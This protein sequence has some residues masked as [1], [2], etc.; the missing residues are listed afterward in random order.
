MEQFNTIPTSGNWSDIAGIIDANFLRCYTALVQSESLVGLSGSNFQGIYTSASSL[1]DD[2]TEAGWALVGTSLSA[3]K[4]YVYN[5]GSTDWALLNDTTYNFTNFT[6]FQTQ[7][8]ALSSQVATIGLKV[9]ELDKKIG[10]TSDFG[11]KIITSSTPTL[12]T[13][14]TV[15]DTITAGNIY[16]ITVS[17]VS[18]GSVVSVSI[19]SAS[20]ASERTSLADTEVTEGQTVTYIPTV[21]ATHWRLWVA[22]ATC[23]ITIS[24]AFSISEKI[25]E[26]D[27]AVQDYVTLGAG[28]NVQ[29]DLNNGFYCRQKIVISEG[30]W[31]WSASGYYSKM[32]QMKDGILYTIV[33]NGGTARYGVVTNIHQ[34]NGSSAGLIDE[35]HSVNAGKYA[36]V[37]GADGLW[38]F[39]RSD[40]NKTYVEPLLYYRAVSRTD[41]LDNEVEE[42]KLDKVI[43]DLKLIVGSSIIADEG[44]AN[45]GGLLVSSQSYAYT[46][47]IDIEGCKRI[48]I[49]TVVC[50]KDYAG[51]GISGAVLYD[52]DKNPISGEGYFVAN[53]YKAGHVS[54]RIFPPSNAVYIR[55]TI[56]SDS[57]LE[58]LA[59]YYE[60]GKART[61]ESKPDIVQR[62]ADSIQAIYAAK[63]MTQLKMSY[64][65]PNHDLNFCIAHITDL[66]C[67]TK[68]YA[69][70]RKF[71]DSV[72]GIDAAILTGDL[73]VSPMAAQFATITTVEGEK[74]VM[75]CVGN[76]DKGEGG[77]RITNSDL[78]TTLG[79]DTDTGQLYYYKDF[80]KTEPVKGT[81]VYKIR[82]IVLN[83]YDA[84]VSNHSTINEWTTYSQAQIDWFI[85]TLQDALANGYAVMIGMHTRDRNMGATH[86]DKKFYD[87]VYD[88]SNMAGYGPDP[89]IEEIVNAFRTGGSLVKDYTWSNVGTTVSVNTSFAS[90]GTFIAYMTGHMHRDYIAYSKNFPD[91]L[92][93]SGNI[94]CLTGEPYTNRP[95]GMEFTAL[96]RVEG[97]KS[98]DCFNVYGID[99]V[100]KMV[101]VVRVGSSLNDF[102]ED[103]DHDIYEF[104]PSIQSND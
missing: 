31:L 6:E 16:M 75:V 3:L 82:V 38:L 84:D 30:N 45:Y 57:P 44:N 101:R 41:R 14:T 97:D 22:D 60:R 49:V 86:N 66:H 4:L 26:V 12:K 34:T 103:V 39:I 73:V 61:T 94:G 10:D 76:H 54:F 48:D 24:R 17:N 20:S 53:A 5:E 52:R 47:Y 35:E 87:R 70:F 28:N 90:A 78:Y 8:D 9:D 69:G 58:N 88:P 51:K 92:Y 72:D 85:E 23:T 68:R 33:N 37:T 100:N 19:G 74:P 59:L 43:P 11:R 32:V 89:I 62:N 1:P 79:L 18:S 99:L 95:Y 91:Q 27:S 56:W 64:N 81:T 15:A 13:L 7:L 42:L 98:E 21:S 93:L 67:D 29:I 50:P 104:Q 71:I 36:E 40:D 2:M 80:T 83:Q 25:E 96:P 77:T 65:N 46:D 102:F 63:K 55:N